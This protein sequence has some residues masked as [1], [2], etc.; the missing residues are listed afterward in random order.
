MRHY[1]HSVTFNS[2]KK[3]KE[4][5]AGNLTSAQY[6]NTLDMLLWK[7]LE[8]IALECPSFFYNFL[9][10]CVAYQTV[11][12]NSKYTSGTKASLPQTLMQALIDQETDPVAAFVKSRK[13]FINR[14]LLFGMVST[15]LKIAE[16]YPDLHSAFTTLPKYEVRTRTRS[17]ELALGA[18][19]PTA[20]YHAIRQVAYWDKRARA[21]KNVILEKYTRMTLGQAQ[22]T[23][24]DFNHF[25]DLDD[26]SQIYLMVASKAVD[27]CDARRGVLTTFIQNWLKGA[28]SQVADLAVDQWDESLEELAD[29]M[30]DSLD[31]GA[32]LPD[33]MMEVMQHLSYKA[34]IADPEGLVRTQ[35]GIPQYVSQQDK[36]ILLSFAILQ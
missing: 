35:L 29:K 8:P 33:R 15:F 4:Q 9:A 21:W 1:S 12:P 6:L 36:Q 30:G 24:V 7:A 32:V 14:G 28:R 2:L 27:R 18:K 5:V 20:L 17:L 13:L 3:T 34:Q 23:Y 10:K 26:V 16:P 22:K 11:N 25:V 19:D 31:L